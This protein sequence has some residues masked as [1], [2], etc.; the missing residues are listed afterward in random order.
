M[1]SKAFKLLLFALIAVAL[2]RFTHYQTSGFRLSKISSNTFLEEEFEA[3]PLT[4][5]ES[6]ILQGKFTYFGRGIQSFAFLSEDG[7]YVLK[8]F[9]N[10]Y[11]RKLKFLEFF[12]LQ[13]YA[14]VV[15]DKLNKT[16]KSYK[17]AYQEL[18][19]ETGVLYLHL[20]PTYLLDRTV[21]VVDKLGIE[22]TIDLD[23]T[24]FLLQKRATL[25]YPQLEKFLKQGNL[26]AAK[27]SL[28]HLLDLFLIKFQRGIADNDPLIRTNYGFIGTTPL[29]IDVGP[30]S[31]DIAMQ[32]PRIYLPELTRITAS[33]KNWLRERSP[34]LLDHVETHLQRLY[35]EKTL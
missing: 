5:E 2:A 8:I 6:K 3:R 18:P 14:N 19:E 9:N 1:K 23:N 17:I 25:V 28:T 31:K 10:R 35:E 34:E 11:Q 21:V 20:S 32:N 29:Q 4:L 27:E 24:G 13:T 30:L 15:K 33:L 7:N 12:Y 26:I 22:H 16:C